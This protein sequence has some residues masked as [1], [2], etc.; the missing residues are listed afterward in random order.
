MPHQPGF[1]RTESWTFSTTIKMSLFF[2][3]GNRSLRHQSQARLRNVKLC[4]PNMMIQPKAVHHPQ[5]Q[6]PIIAKHPWTKL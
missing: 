3:H 4:L 2:A 6:V 5:T 1:P